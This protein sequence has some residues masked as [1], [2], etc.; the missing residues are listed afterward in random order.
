MDYKDY[1][2]T[3]EFYFVA[4]WSSYLNE[5]RY[6]PEKKIIFNKWFLLFCCNS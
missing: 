3:L 5:V 6:L 2:L 1:I 4:D